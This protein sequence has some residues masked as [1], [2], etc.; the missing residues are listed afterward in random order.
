MTPL[1]LA[2]LAAEAGLPEGVFNVVPGLGEAAGQAI[3]RHSD[4][5]AVAFTGSTE[6]GRLFLK[7]AAESNMKRIILECGGKSPQVVLSDAGDLDNVARNAVNSGV[8]GT[9][10]RTAAPD[11][12]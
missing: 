10:A 8:S 3:G 6:V 1:R 2:E 4:I 12:A 5:D 7:Y 9:W 11:C